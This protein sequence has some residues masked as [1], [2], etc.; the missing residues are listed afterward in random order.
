MSKCQKE[1]VNPETLGK[2]VC[3]NET[4][5]QEEDLDGELIYVCDECVERQAMIGVYMGKAGG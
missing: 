4:E 2:S 1:W 5:R 3:G